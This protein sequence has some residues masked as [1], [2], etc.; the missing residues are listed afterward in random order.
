MEPLVSVICITRNHE[1][2][3]IEA[4]DSILNQTYKNLEWIILDAA[5]SD[6]TPQIIEDWLVANK[7][8]AIFIKEK[9]LKPIT[10]NL[11][12]TLTFAKGEYIQVISLDD[13]LVK[14]K[15]VVQ[16]NKFKIDEKLGVIF[17]DALKIDTNGKYLDSIFGFNSR[18]K[19]S[20]ENDDIFKIIVNGNQICAATALVRK[21]VYRECGSYDENI[22][23]ED[24]DFWLRV[25]KSS[26][27][28]KYFSHVLVKYRIS[29]NSLWHIGNSKIILS[30]IDI[31]DK[32]NYSQCN[33]V[34]LNY[35]IYFKKNSINDKIKVFFGIIKRR[36]INLLL[37]Y[38]CSILFYDREKIRKYSKKLTK[39]QY[40]K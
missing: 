39:F 16:V 26:W 5:S 15:I 23:I 37:I 25:L 11:N 31:L 4:L 8:V 9:E 40:K 10:V 30:I 24:W 34:L 7:I 38:L 1:R 13:I 12:K 19:E 21:E 20:L 29:E 28:M 36:K 6:N 18:D 17:G 2:F 32:H 14:D 33:N 35:F 27:K 22:H 3:C